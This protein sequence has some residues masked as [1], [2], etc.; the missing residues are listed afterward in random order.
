[1]VRCQMTMLAY[2]TPKSGI[3]D[4]SLSAQGLSPRYTESKFF[5]SF[6][7]TWGAYA[8]AIERHLD[9]KII[10]VKICHCKH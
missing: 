7:W 1:M 4:A 2:F 3:V 5:P 10:I 8:Y 6:N 9:F